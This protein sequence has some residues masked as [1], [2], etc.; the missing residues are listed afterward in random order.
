M[1]FLSLLLAENLHHTNAKLSGFYTVDVPTEFTSQNLFPCH[2]VRIVN[3][4]I[5]IHLP[6]SIHPLIRILHVRIRGI[7]L[8]DTEKK[9]T[10]FIKN[11]VLKSS[12]ILYLNLKWDKGHGQISADVY[13]DDHPLAELLIEQGLATPMS[14]PV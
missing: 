2:I 11:A 10:S 14:E 7:D 13:L 9:A 6:G 4:H 8:S 3:G 1:L 5:I 12:K